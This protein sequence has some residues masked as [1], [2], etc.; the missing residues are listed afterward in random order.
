MAKVETKLPTSPSTLVVGFLMLLG[1]VLGYVFTLVFVNQSQMS[2]KLRNWRENQASAQSLRTLQHEVVTTKADRLAKETRIL[3]WIL[4]QPKSHYKKAV[5]VKNTWGKRCDKLIFMSTKNVVT[6]KADRLAKET[7]ILCWILTQPKSHYKKAVHVKNTWGK[8]C[9]KLIF[10]STKNDEKLGAVALN[11]SEGY[12]NLWGK[13]KAAFKYV[14][15]HH[16]DE[17]D[18][19][20]KADDDTY[21][22]MEN[23]RYMLCSY[24]PKY[25]IYFGSKFRRFYKEGFLGGGSGYVL[26]REATRKLVEEA[27]PNK[28]KCKAGE[29]GLEDV[30]LGTFM[31]LLPFDLRF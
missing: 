27:M 18:W 19:F 1:S 8:R 25:P 29:R 6:T 2:T 26:S 4:T 30:E 14:Y 23:M 13:T 5:H 28:T 9:D 3:C 24:D 16:L 10:M 11:T 21:T 20:L 31:R 15:D 7:R 17:Y 12:Y 22:I